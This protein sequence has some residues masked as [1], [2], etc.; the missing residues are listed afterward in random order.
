MLKLA[1]QSGLLTITEAANAIGI[2]RAQLTQSVKAGTSPP[3][4]KLGK[5]LYFKKEDA[6][7][8]KALHY[9]NEAIQKSY[10]EGTAGEITIIERDED[11]V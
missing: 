9:F 1:S 3:A 4:I 5:R 8:E 11:L 6:T 2:S 10:R 7:P